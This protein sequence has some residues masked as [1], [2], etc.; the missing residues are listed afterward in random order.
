MPATWPKVQLFGSGLG[1]NGSTMNCGMPPILAA[2]AELTISVWASTGP[3]TN[4]VTT[5]AALARQRVPIFMFSSR[6]ILVQDI[7]DQSELISSGV[8]A[9]PA[10]S[11][12]HGSAFDLQQAVEPTG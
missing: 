4:A 5:S 6:G 1:Q 3:E 7:S 2:A 8:N 11:I 12:L 9:Q 10:S